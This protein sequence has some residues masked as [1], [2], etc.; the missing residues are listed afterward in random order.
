MWLGEGHTQQEEYEKKKK[1]LPYFF[2]IYPVGENLDFLFWLGWI[3]RYKMQAE[4]VHA[5]HVAVHQV[6][7]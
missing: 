1:L 7:H 5:A 4:I 3:V 2:L 6:L